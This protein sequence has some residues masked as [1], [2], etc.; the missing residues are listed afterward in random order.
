MNTPAWRPYL[1]SLTAANAAASP[2]AFCTLRTGP[3][4]SS[5]ARVVPAGR[6]V[7]TVGA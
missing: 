1:E 3:K 7:S 5:Q 6:S 4:T 2:S